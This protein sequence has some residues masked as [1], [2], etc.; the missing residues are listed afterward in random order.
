ME[1]NRES[2]WI[3][4]SDELIPFDLAGRNAGVF[5]ERGPDLPSRTPEQETKKEDRH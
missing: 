1:G 5:P 4:Y 3:P 2:E